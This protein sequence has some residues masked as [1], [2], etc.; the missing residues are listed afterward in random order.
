MVRNQ[1]VFGVFRDVWLE[2]FKIFSNHGGISRNN[3]IKLAC[4]VFDSICRNLS[5]KVSKNSPTKVGLEVIIISKTFYRRMYKSTE[6]ILC[7][8]YMESTMGYG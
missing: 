3:Y 2:V 7:E 4:F 1:R 6:K 8:V 5:R